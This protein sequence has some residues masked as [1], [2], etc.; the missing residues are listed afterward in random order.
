MSVS[1]SLCQCRVDDNYIINGKIAEECMFFN[2]KTQT[3][4]HE[5]K[6][7]KVDSSGQ[8]SVADTCNPSYLRDQP[9]EIDHETLS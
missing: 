7:K 6:R 1:I 9:T 3:S 2:H 5:K 4:V 8:A